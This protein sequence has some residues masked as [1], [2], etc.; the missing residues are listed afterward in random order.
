MFVSGI[1]EDGPSIC[2]VHVDALQWNEYIIVLLTHSLDLLNYEQSYFQQQASS[3][4]QHIKQTKQSKYEMHDFSSPFKFLWP[5][6]SIL[7][8]NHLNLK[9]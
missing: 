9:V 5:S 2:I 4:F 8:N 6:L 3:Y 7:L 1:P